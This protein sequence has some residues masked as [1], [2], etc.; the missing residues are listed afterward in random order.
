LGTPRAWVWLSETLFSDQLRVTLP[1]LPPQERRK[2]RIGFCNFQLI[3]QF[4][5]FCVPSAYDHRI[6]LTSLVSP[7]CL[8]LPPPTTRNPDLPTSTRHASQVTP[9][10]PTPCFSLTRQDAMLFFTV[11]F[12]VSPCVRMKFSPL[13]GW[14]PLNRVGS[15]FPIGTV[16]EG[17]VPLYFI[18]GKSIS[19]FSRLKHVCIASLDKPNYFHSNLSLVQ[20][21]FFLTPQDG[22]V[23]SS[24]YFTSSFLPKSLLHEPP[25][26]PPLLTIHI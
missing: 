22:T 24:T 10:H 19:L 6:D 7:R 3:P 4:T 13:F 8:S 18:F 16:F 5:K 12:P 21:Q 23:L 25:P 26:I 17:L 11:S 20:F 9:P 1:H 15:F 14:A 2:P